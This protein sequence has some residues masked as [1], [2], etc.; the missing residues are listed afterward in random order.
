MYSERNPRSSAVGSCK[1][2]SGKT[3]R[4]A[5]WKKGDMGRLLQDLGDRGGCL[6]ARAS[7]GNDYD[8]LCHP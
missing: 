3:P 4:Q 5:G 7:E 6:E 1:K 8:L 2:L